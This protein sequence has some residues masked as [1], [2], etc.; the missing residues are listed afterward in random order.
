MNNTLFLYCCIIIS[1]MLT[2]ERNHVH[3]QIARDAVVFV[4]SRCEDPENGA[5]LRPK[6]SGVVVDSRGF[7]LTAAHVVDCKLNVKRS[8]GSEIERQFKRLEVEVIKGSSRGQR[9]PVDVFGM[10]RER[11]VAVLMFASAPKRHESAITCRLPEVQPETPFVAYGFPEGETYQ[12]VPGLLGGVNNDGTWSA[13]SAF[14]EGM[15]GGPVVIGGRVVGLVKGGAGLVIAR[16]KIAPLFRATSAITDTIGWT[17]PFC[18]ELNKFAVRIFWAIEE[19]K[20]ERQSQTS[21]RQGVSTGSLVETKCETFSFLPTDGWQ[22]AIN[23]ITLVNRIEQGTSQATIEHVSP[24]E[25]RVRFCARSRIVGISKET[26]DSFGAIRFDEIKEEKIKKDKV[27][28]FTSQG[29]PLEI[30]IPQGV[31]SWR[32]EIAGIGEGLANFSGP[33]RHG[34]YLVSENDKQSMTIKRMIP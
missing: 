32:G 26:G 20:I 23:T 21:P 25:V 30:N 6:G 24:R 7:I 3:A 5:I 31:I 13:V 1:T 4:E 10:D 17:L 28:V 8:D 33:G 14:A 11:D 9:E 22:F 16:R 15:S 18:D 12:P 34:R 27:D 29:D 19:L 2:A